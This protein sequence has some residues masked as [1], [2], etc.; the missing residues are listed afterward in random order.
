MARRFE[1]DELIDYF[2][3]LPDELA[4]LRNKSGAT[5]LGFAVM[6]KHFTVHGRFPAARAE[7]AEEVVEFVAQQVGVPA[8]EIAFYDWAG[9]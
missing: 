4:L 3:L 8:A 9:R 6:L 7:L 1:L 5:R 2:T